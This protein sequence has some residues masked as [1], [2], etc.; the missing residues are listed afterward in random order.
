MTISK[1]KLSG[2]AVNPVGLGCMN[3]CWAYGP[4]VTD[5]Y[6]KRLL[7][8]A[9]D[10]GYD[11][12]DT[13]R[14]YGEGQSEALIGEALKGR[15]QEYFLAS[16]TGIVIDGNDRRIDCKP[17]TIKAACETSLKLLQT[18]HI[19]LYYLH[20]RDFTVPIEESV[21]ALSDLIKEG[22][23]GS[24]GLSEMS[25]D[26]LR[27][28]HAVHPCAAMQTEY[29][30]MTRQPEIAVLDMCQV[31]GVTFV[32]FSPVGRG[33]LAGR[34]AE[35]HDWQAGDLRKNW[36][37]FQEPN[38]S[39]NLRLVEGYAR[40]AAAAGVTP[41]QLSMGWIHAKG[42]HI[43]TIPGS[44]KIEHV[45]ENIA[46][47]DWEPDAAIVAEVDALINQASVAGPRYPAAMQRAIDTEDF[48]MEV[49]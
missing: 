27:R 5:D 14:I 10:L 7:N 23:I 48:A 45:E 35:G 28:A 26:T 38:F 34:L 37:R 13:A 21:G 31:L 32:A 36:P 49:G 43:I 17:E 11:H 1:R 18:D 6:A 25:A 4:A 39:A 29:S 42:D 47:W 24:Y 3:I 15:R 33:L 8:T 16:K 12:L 46:R 44:Q 41:A 22:K 9:L 19:D 40:I 30:P 2:R 20:R